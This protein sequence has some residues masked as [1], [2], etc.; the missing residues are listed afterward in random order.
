MIN[1]LSPPDSEADIKSNWVYKDKVYISF[2][3]I[4]YNQELYI[5]DAVD[6]FL[7]QKSK[8]KFEIIIHDD[9]STDKTKDILLEYKEKYPTLIKLIFQDVN[10][11][12][13]GNK[14]IPL[15]VKYAKG[16]YIA[17]CEGDDFWFDE[18][19]IDVQYEYMYKKSDI[20]FH[21]CFYIDERTE[22]IEERCKHYSHN[23]VVSVNEVFKNGGEFMPTASLMIKKSVF[24]NLPPWFNNV[25]AGD[26][27]LQVL[28]S[29]EYG[30]M[31][32]DNLRSIYRYYSVGSWTESNQNM[33]KQKIH[34][35][36]K[37][38]ELHL[39]RLNEEVNV[40]LSKELS[41]VLA[42][43]YNNAA[44][45]CI[46]NGYLNEYK[47]YIK[48]SWSEFKLFSR[49]QCVRYKLRHFPRS[50]VFLFK[51]SNLYNKLLNLFKGVL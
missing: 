44:S 41:Y 4:T 25:P 18:Y 1:K 28:A 15:A 36:V 11:F 27:Y 10:Q 9:C 31:Y 22:E 48:K 46:K 33:S 17:L 35:N 30:A 13:L 8:Y 3:C 42:R 7:S 29:N 20:S 38:H 32:I 50:V 47:Y 49:S 6:S 2:V 14:I 12:S 19:K 16:D 40:K 51:I 37:C 26:F 24:N 39:I 34:D 43:V 23:K 5:K 21:P 45:L